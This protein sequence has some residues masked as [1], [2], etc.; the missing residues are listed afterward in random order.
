MLRSEQILINKLISI[1]FMLIETNHPQKIYG[2]GEGKDE[3]VRRIEVCSSKPIVA[4]VF[5]IPD[6]GKT[7]LIDYLGTR[8]EAKGLDVRQRSNQWKIN[9]YESWAHHNYEKIDRIAEALISKDL[10]IYHCPWDNRARP[11]KGQIDPEESIRSAM[12][13]GLDLSVGIFNP[14]RSSPPTGNFDLI[15]SNQNSLEKPFWLDD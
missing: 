5:G 14:I 1:L 9:W 3:A 6:S 4:G 12:G 15:I 13:R 2:F 7:Y 10:A 8:F 11:W